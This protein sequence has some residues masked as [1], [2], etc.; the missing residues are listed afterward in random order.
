MK[1]KHNFERLDRHFE[2]SELA[3]KRYVLNK[4]QLDGYEVC[5]KCHK[6]QR[7][8]KHVLK[9]MFWLDECW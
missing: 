1:C 2:L 7:T 3:I 9:E 6:I 5:T 4:N 8:L